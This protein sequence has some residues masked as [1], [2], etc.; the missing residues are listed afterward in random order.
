MLK[1]VLYK[2]E[3]IYHGYGLTL[4]PRLSE[5]ALGGDRLSWIRELLEEE[6]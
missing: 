6:E 1:P 4:W 2:K 3:G 5:R